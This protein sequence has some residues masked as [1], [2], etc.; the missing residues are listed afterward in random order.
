MGGSSGGGSSGAVDYPDYM[1]DWH[2]DVLGSGALG[3]DDVTGVM[4]AALGASPWAGAVAFDPDTDIT[5]WEAAITGFDAILAGIDPTV[6][7]ATLFVQAGASIAVADKT[8]ADMAGVAGI[9]EALITADSLAFSDNLDD[10]ITTKVLPRYEGG[11]RDINAVVSS[12][13]VIG[14]GIIESFRT[15]DVAK[16][17]S[18]LRFNAANK[19][20]DIE[21]AEGTANLEKNVKVAGINIQK[22]IAVTGME[23]EATSQMIRIFLQNIAWEESLTKMVVESRRIKIVAKSEETQQSLEYDVADAL[24]DLEVFK[25]GGNMLAAIGSAS[26]SEG[27]KGPTKTQSAVGGAMAGGAMGGAMAGASAGGMTGPQG[28]VVGAIIG[29]A[30][31]YYMS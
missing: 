20:A 30:Y 2:K 25:Y 23:I 19:N 17:E 28:A 12:A 16:H 31:G 1:K 14:E 8:V 15:R 10:E 3:G 27:M 18:G 22:D 24:W 7:W 26:V 5:A 21:L 29:A 13:F 6:D 11:M 4:A 9:T